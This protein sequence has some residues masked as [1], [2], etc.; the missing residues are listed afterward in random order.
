[1]YY[2]IINVIRYSEFP[3]SKSIF[4]CQSTIHY[5]INIAH[6]VNPRAT[7][8]FLFLRLCFVAFW[9]LLWPLAS[10]HLFH[11]ETKF[12]WLF[13]IFTFLE[14]FKFWTITFRILNL[15]CNCNAISLTVSQG[16]GPVF[17][18]V[19]VF[20]RVFEV[21]RCQLA[22]ITTIFKT[23]TFFKMQFEYWFQ[24]ITTNSIASLKLSPDLL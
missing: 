18:F 21:R 13:C 6:F 19:S 11:S 2:T 7:V 10:E 17:V 16:H 12:T 22:T 9:G 15:H 1:M 20:R 4:Q 8:L 24:H 23:S 14:N 5:S 3:F